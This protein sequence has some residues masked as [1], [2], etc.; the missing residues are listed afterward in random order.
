MFFL[1]Y[2]LTIKLQ[3][4]IF[5]R[6]FIW[7][8]EKLLQDTTGKCIYIP[9]WDW[10]RD[11]EWEHDA[12]VMHWATFGGWGDSDGSGCA[13]SGITHYH[14]PFLNSPGVNNGREGCV[15][16]EFRNGFSFSG[17]AQVLATISNYDQY[18]DTTGNR[19][20]RPRPGT[21]NGFRHEI[22]NGPHRLIHVIIGGHMR[23]NYSP[24]DPL[25]YLHHSNVDRIWSM[26]QDYWDH[27]TLDADDYSAPFQ[28]DSEWGMDQRLSYAPS[29]GISSWDFKMHYQDSE[30]DFPTVREVLDNDGPVL[31]VR[32]QNSYLTVLMPDYEPNLRLFQ[33]A[34]DTVPV[35]CDRDGWESN[36]R[37]LEREKKQQETDEGDIEPLTTLITM[38]NNVVPKRIFPGVFRSSLRGGDTQEI[39]DNLESFFRAP[40]RVKNALNGNGIG[41]RSSSADI[42]EVTN[43]YC[44]R[45]PV[46]TIQEDR[47]E[48]DHLCQKLPANTTMA[49]RLAML[50]EFD[51]N[52]RGNPRSD[53]PELNEG[54]TMTAFVDPDAPL[55]SF[56]CFHRPDAVPVDRK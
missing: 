16:R 39:E 55:S 34:T 27:D 29:E 47:D 37:K 6:W 33:P 26:W 4:S 2:S 40:V 20:P 25:F 32:Y 13:T 22:E 49:E 24:A 53:A 48:W 8:F 1:M 15:T 17:E 51:C 7:N 14:E 9:Y 42:V 45:P 50:A 36:R 30:P 5:F 44:G 46:F 52:R 43:D 41:I 23:T 31:S 38:T 56:E 12:D 54:M 28:Y 3:N 18:S 19:N 21:T 11:A 10:E 35:K